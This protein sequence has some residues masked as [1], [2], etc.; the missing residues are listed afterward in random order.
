MRDSEFDEDGNKKEKSIEDIRKAISKQVPSG[1]VADGPGQSEEADLQ[2]AIR[3]DPD[4]KDG[5]LKMADYYK[6]NGKHEEALG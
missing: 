2:R 4:N 1:A 5:Y 6:R 3:K